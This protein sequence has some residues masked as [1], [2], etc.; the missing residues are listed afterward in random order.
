MI[1]TLPLCTAAFLTFAAVPVMAQSAFDGTWKGDVTSSSVEAKPDQ[2]AI[3]NGVYSCASCLPPFSVKA[4][5]AF[6]AVKDKPYWDEIAVKVVDASSVQYRYRKGGKEVAH[7]DLG[8]SADG[9]TLSIRTSNTNNGGGVPVETT[10]TEARLAAAPAGAHAV[11]GSWKA[12]PATSVSD[13]ALTMTLKVDA[14]MVHLKSPLGETLDAR[15]GGDFAVNAGDPGKTMTKAER[16]SPTSI[17]LT[18][19]RLGK[20]VQVSTYTVS[21]DGATL[22]GEW[23]DPR[24]GS[25]GAFVARKQ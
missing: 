1:R 18:D 6:H 19:M 11:S 16:L 3:S 10:A 23:Q 15:F 21:A 5:G 24:D 7:A 2:F 12:T 4:D 22:N 8:V 25:K 17:R 13:A 14:D 9:D 20:V